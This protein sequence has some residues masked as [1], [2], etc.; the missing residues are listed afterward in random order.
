MLGSK[1]RVIEGDIGS[2]SASD[3]QTIFKNQ[4][5]LAFAAGSDERIP[6]EGDPAAFYQRENVELIEPMVKTAADCGIKRVV[7]LNS[8]FS[9]L[10]RSRP[11]IGLAKSHPYIASRVAQ[12]DMALSVAKGR[13]IMT[14]PKRSSAVPVGDQWLSWGELLS[15]LA[16][17]C[18]RESVQL[19]RIPDNLLVQ[20]NELSGFWQKLF[21]L[22]SGLDYGKIHQFL[23]DDQP[24]NLKASQRKL[25]YRPDSITQSLRESVADVPE[26]RTI[27]LVRE[28]VIS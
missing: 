3:W 15:R 26:S 21:R 12:R 10:D 1:V 5:N 22:K 16:A 19:Q 27:K 7:L 4:A 6:P 17:C 11:E 9:T 14:L 8:I 13:F 20:L 28:L 24:I 23:L 2:M 18:E 25:G